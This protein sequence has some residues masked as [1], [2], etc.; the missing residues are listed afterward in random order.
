MDVTVHDTRRD[1]CVERDTSGACYKPV[2]WDRYLQYIADTASTHHQRARARVRLGLYWA[3][4]IDRT[5]C[6]GSN[7][8]THSDTHSRHSR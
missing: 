4:S 3:R 5:S 7:T 1:V 2:S 6:S 8:S